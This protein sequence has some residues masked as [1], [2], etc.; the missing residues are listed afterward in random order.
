MK[1]VKVYH[2]DSFSTEANK[3]NPAGVVLT[4]E[5]LTTEEMQEIALKVGFNETTF[6]INSDRAD[7]GLRFFT[8]GHEMTLCGHGTVATLYAL[9]TTGVL[10]KTEVTVETKAGVLPITIG[11]LNDQVAIKMTQATPEFVAFNGNQ[12]ELAHV[13]G[14]TPDEIDENLPIVY[15]STGTWTLLVPIKKLTT[16]EQMKPVNA[17]FPEVLQEMP[18]VSIHPFCFETYDATADMHGRHFSSPLS[19]TVEDPVTGTASGVMGAYVAKY[20]HENQQQHLQLTIEQGQE[21]KRNGRVKVTVSVEQEQ[22]HIA[23]T[24]TAVYVQAFDIVLGK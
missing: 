18:N 15:G 20:I 11:Q 12:A 8:P 5:E 9:Q 24:G 4:G 22:M 6:V 10:T 3:G 19:G 21:I 13:M 17:Q 23:I 16:F 7:V 14:I 2:Y 1:S